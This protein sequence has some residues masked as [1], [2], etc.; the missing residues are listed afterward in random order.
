MTARNAAWPVSISFLPAER[1]CPSAPNASAARAFCSGL[2]V[3]CVP[4]QVNETRA[5]AMVERS[6]WAGVVSAVAERP[7][8]ERVSM[9]SIRVLIFPPEEWRG[10]AVP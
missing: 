7:L 9:R 6:R 8:A 2:R 5:A 3:F 1:Y 10:A 4:I